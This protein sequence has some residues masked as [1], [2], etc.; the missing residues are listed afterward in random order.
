M[1]KNNKTLDERIADLYN[2]LDTLTANAHNNTI[3]TDTITINTQN[4]VQ[5]ERCNAELEKLERERMQ[6]IISRI[7]TNNKS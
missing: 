6:S 5:I 2:E 4:D 7:N 3:N 1:T